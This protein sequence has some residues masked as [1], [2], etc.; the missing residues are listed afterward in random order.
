M[1]EKTWSTSSNKLKSNDLTSQKDQDSQENL[2][3]CTPD[4]KCVIIVSDNEPI[5]M[6]EYQLC[7]VLPAVHLH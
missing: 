7:Y 6:L 3:I 1:W 5:R 4:I 2:T